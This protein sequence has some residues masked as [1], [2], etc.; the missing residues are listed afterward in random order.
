MCVRGWVKKCRPDHSVVW[1]RFFIVDVR[2][3]PEA[4]GRAKTERITAREAGEWERN[5]R[6]EE[7]AI[8]RVGSWG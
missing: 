7:E 2:D 6:N 4:S 8:R 5:R 3:Q 1:L